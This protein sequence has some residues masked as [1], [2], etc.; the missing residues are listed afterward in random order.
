[1]SKKIENGGRRV[2]VDL[3]S[4]VIHKLDKARVYKGTI[5]SITDTL[6]QIIR[7]VDITKLWN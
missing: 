4:D 3:A 7:K 2:T 6:E 1:M 5:K